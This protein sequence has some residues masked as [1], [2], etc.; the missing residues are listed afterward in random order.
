M[1]KVFVFSLLI[2]IPFFVPKERKVE[3]REKGHESH[4]ETRDFIIIKSFQDAMHDVSDFIIHKHIH[5]HIS[6]LSF[7]T[8]PTLLFTH[9][10][11]LKE[12]GTLR[13]DVKVEQT[14]NQPYNQSTIF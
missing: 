12:Q 1:Y 11:S 10:H 3:D 7:T 8:Y 5:R 2:E 9:A 14:T 4:I 13:R 6:K